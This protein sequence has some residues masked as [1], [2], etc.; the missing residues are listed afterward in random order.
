MSKHHRLLTSLTG[1]TLPR[2]WR[3]VAASVVCALV[4]FSCSR[5]SPPPAPWSAPPSKSV[6][7][8]TGSGAPIPA[9]SERSQGVPCGGLGCLQFET[10][11]AAF[12]HVLAE[13]PLVLAIGE[14]HAQRG[15]PTVPSA[16]SQFTERLLPLL[17]GEASDLVL[18]LWAPDPKCS[19]EQVERV[20]KEQKPVTEAQR[21]DNQNEFTA[22]GNRSHALGIRPHVLTPPC[23]EYGRIIA[24]GPDG[25]DQMLKLIARMTDVMLEAILER[26]QQR[27]VEKIAVAYG[28]AMHNDLFPREGREAWSF[29]PQL[30]DYTRRRYV[31]LDLIVPE[32]IQATDSW[33]SLPWYS[34]Y[35]PARH[36]G[37]A[38]LFQQGP[39]SYVLVFAAT[40]PPAGAPPA[41]S[42]PEA[43]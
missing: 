7:P 35:Q 38:T 36:G 39:G 32:F 9:H 26:N 14:A 20:E 40:D 28:G 23:E 17:A 21:E 25:V 18:E 8:P 31:E 1:P 34:H 16:T 12:A 5:G 24:A 33:R 43:R 41:S 13:E 15:A 4:G 11:E 3:R 19:P 2:T 30:S 37:R 29:G 27:N 22:L 42:A 6:A 10:P